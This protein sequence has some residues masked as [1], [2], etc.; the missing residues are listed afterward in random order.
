MDETAAGR[1]SIEE[2]LVENYGDSPERVRQKAIKL[3]ESS[4]ARKANDSFVGGSETPRFRRR[5][6]SLAGGTLAGGGSSGSMRQPRRSRESAP[7]LT[8]NAKLLTILH[9]L[10]YVKRDP[11][12]ALAVAEATV[13]T[14][15]LNFKRCAFI[16]ESSSFARTQPAGERRMSHRASLTPLPPLP[17]ACTTGSF[18]ERKPSIQPSVSAPNLPIRVLP[19]PRKLLRAELYAD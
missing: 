2:V 9:T 4:A 18:N 6:N 12:R 8:P 3:R 1:T 14:N 7:W 5:S 11:S 17:G 16:Q 15:Q 10:P 19:P 13:E